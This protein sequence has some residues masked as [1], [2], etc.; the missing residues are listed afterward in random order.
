MH[1]I[2]VLA[3]LGAEIPV[4]GGGVDVCGPPVADVSSR[5]LITFVWPQALA[6]SSS[7]LHLDAHQ[8][9]AETRRP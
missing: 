3:H 2:F 4:H 8:S 5:A 1:K 9:I 6:S 7:H